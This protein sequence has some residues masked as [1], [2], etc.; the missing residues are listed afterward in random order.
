MFEDLEGINFSGY[1]PAN[2]QPPPV[3]KGRI[4]GVRQMFMLIN[5]SKKIKTHPLVIYEI[6]VYLN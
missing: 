4:E 6:E 5:K 1:D 3:E 2:F